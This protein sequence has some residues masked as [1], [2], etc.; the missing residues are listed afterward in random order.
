M[1]EPRI[2]VENVSKKFKIG[3][4]KKQTFLEKSVSLFSGRELKKELWALKDVSFTLNPG[5]CVGIIGRNGAG[6]STLLKIIAGIINTNEGI[7]KTAGR[8][9][10]VMETLGAQPR[11]S[12]KDSIFLYC[13]LC[14]LKNMETEKILKP[15][16]D[17]SELERFVN[18][19]IYQ[20]SAGMAQRL[21]A[22]IIVY[23]NQPVILIDDF[24]TSLIDTAFLDKWM[25]R[26]KSL[27]DRGAALVVASHN[28]CD[29][30]KYCGRIIYLDAG[31]IVKIGGS[32]EVIGFYN[33]SLDN[34]LR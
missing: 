34:I 2:V 24:S 7:I 26:I 12:M 32:R 1:S 5:E 8:I 28:L 13:S 6:K 31:Q 16:I 3:C 20:F 30:E 19:K 18:T 21:F 27:I 22:S 25:G 14:G 17:F 29:L 10:P 23:I 4:D 33:S 15:I 9:V 11:L